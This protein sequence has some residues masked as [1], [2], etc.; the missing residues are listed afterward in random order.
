[1]LS[2]KATPAKMYNYEVNAII[3]YLI[4]HPTET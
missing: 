4:K 1:M 2:G 3:I